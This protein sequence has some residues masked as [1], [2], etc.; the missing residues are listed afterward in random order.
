LTK[1]L[2]VYLASKHSQVIYWPIS[3]FLLWRKHGIILS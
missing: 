3:S 2:N 1:T